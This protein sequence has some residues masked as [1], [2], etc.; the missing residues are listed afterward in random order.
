MLVGALLRRLSV[1]QIGIK[2]NNLSE[3]RMPA[4][5]A[6]CVKLIEDNRSNSLSQFKRTKLQAG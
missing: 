6:L 5:R 4:L 2:K 3:S 1:K